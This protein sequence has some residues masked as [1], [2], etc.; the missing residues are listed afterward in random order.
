MTKNCII[1]DSGSRR[2]FSS[3][4]VRDIQT[5]KGRCDLLPLE[6]VGCL[7]E[8]LPF[9]KNIFEYLD[10]FIYSGDVQM[11]ADALKVFAKACDQD[12]S[13]MLLDVSVHYEEGSRKYGE[14]NWEKGIPLHCYIDSGTRH[15]LKFLRGD[16]DEPH[17]R[18]F[19]WNMLGA[20]WTRTH[21]PE[22]CDLPYVNKLNHIE[23]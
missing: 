23:T 13:T 6:S 11:L 18:A 17:G 21:L 3:G 4:A 8:G 20:M 7:F 16:D 10:T 1:L 5:G 19:V 2:E 12:I 14:H 15:L 9:A 22:C